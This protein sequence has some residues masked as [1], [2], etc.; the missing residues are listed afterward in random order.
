M[1]RLIP[2]SRVM[3]ASAILAAVL[4]GAHCGL[5]IGD[6]LCLAPALVLAAT[7]LACRYPGERLLVALAGS[8]GRRAARTRS[9]SQSPASRPAS[10]VPRGGL[11]IAFALA[12]R[13]PPTTLLAG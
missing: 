7:L 8:R 4:L 12:V 2:R 1:L 3:A 10:R 9:V 5:A 11:L 6:L 13:P